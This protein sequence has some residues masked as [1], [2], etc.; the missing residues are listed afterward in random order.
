MSLTP[1]ALSK[2]QKHTE[3]FEPTTFLKVEEAPLELELNG[4]K[5]N[6]PLKL[7]QR[8]LNGQVA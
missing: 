2:L 6:Q 4:K 8:C 3:S 5:V 1:F 7:E